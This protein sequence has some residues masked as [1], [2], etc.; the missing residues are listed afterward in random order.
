VK[1][2][3]AFVAALLAGCTS[4]GADVK[5]ICDA[6]KASHLETVADDGKHETFMLEWASY[7]IHTTEGKQ[8]LAKISAPGLSRQE[9]T[10]LLRQSAAQT[11]LPECA[12]ADWLDRRK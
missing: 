11:A 6:P 7:N 10:R 12:F 3:L 9:R 2:A 4:Y 8:L 1:R 5:T